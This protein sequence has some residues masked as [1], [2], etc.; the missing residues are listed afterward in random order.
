MNGFLIPMILWAIVG[1]IV[2]SFISS[3]LLFLKLNAL[4][5]AWADYLF[6]CTDLVGEGWGQLALAI[7]FF[8]QKKRSWSLMLAITFSFSGLVSQFMKKVMFPDA[9]R[10]L[11]YF[12][13]YGIVPQSMPWIHVHEHN[14]FPS[15]HTITCF[16][17][18]CC[19][20]L[21]YRKPILG[22][23]FFCGAVIGCYSRIYE[24]QHF[25]ID[26]FAGAIVG[27]LSNLI[28]YYI[29]IKFFP[30]YSLSLEKSSIS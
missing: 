4:R 24:A 20:A 22:V 26:V 30:K 23:I 10:P 7:I 18:F 6:T 15:G 5:A 13:E 29:Y 28:V 2:F 14:S 1:G 11:A 21:F 9:L 27:V 25:P 3:P 17:L 8:F 16:S 19:L 12:R